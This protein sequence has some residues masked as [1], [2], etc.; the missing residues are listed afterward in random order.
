MFTNYYVFLRYAHEDP[1]PE[2]QILIED[3][4]ER[5]KISITLNGE[6]LI[7]DV[8]LQEVCSYMLLCTHF[9]VGTIKKTA[10]NP[11]SFFPN[12][13]FY[14]SCSNTKLFEGHRMIYIFPLLNTYPLSFLFPFFSFFSLPSLYSSPL[15]PPSQER[16]QNQE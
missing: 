8:S 1:L 12:V 6:I 5:Y 16:G 3:R 15:F 10:I 11:L 2:P 9:R 7:A 4:E 13:I 14:L